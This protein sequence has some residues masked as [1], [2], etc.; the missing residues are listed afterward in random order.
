ML[1]NGV[2]QVLFVEGLTLTRAGDA[3]IVMATSPALI[4]IVGRIHGSE[5]VG[6]RAAAG[7]LLSMSGIA[8]VVLGGAHAGVKGSSIGGDLLIFAGLFCWAVYAILLTPYTRRV[9]GVT[10]SAYTMLGGML[11]VVSVALPELARTAWGSVPPR[12]WGAIAF[13]GLGALVVAYLFWYRGVRVI[14]P[15]RT[16]MNS[17]LQPVF[18]LLMAWAMLA[19]TPTVWQGVGVASVTVGLLLTRA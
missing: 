2:Y 12:A 1:G 7:M 3:A 8:W 19:E 14:G 15:T 4:A 9:D 5:R 16:A 10:L 17:N 6:A 18:A 11:V 13:S